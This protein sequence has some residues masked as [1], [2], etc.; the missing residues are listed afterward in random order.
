MITPSLV[1][2]FPKYQMCQNTVIKGK[3][4][5]CVL[6]P[7]ARS[8]AGIV[9]QNLFSQSKCFFKHGRVDDW[10]FSPLFASHTPEL[11]FS[12]LIIRILHM[13]RECEYGAIVRSRASVL[14]CLSQIHS[15]Y[16]TLGDLMLHFCQK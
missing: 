1:S 7:L 8:A 13:V 16:T 4:R 10:D 11:I 9:T 6:S 14:N 2:Y 3:D 12:S 15:Q 5:N